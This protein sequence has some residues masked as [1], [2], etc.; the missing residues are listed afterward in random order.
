MYNF[1]QQIA[2]LNFQKKFEK[3]ASVKLRR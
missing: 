2:K 1:S 3:R